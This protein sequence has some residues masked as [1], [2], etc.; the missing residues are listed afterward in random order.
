MRQTTYWLI[1]INPVEVVMKHGD[2]RASKSKELLK[3]RWQ[4]L[5]QTMSE[6]A[7]LAT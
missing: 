2:K 6:L 7:W 5:L 1:V 3:Q 4:V